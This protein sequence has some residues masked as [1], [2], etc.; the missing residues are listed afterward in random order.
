M[1]RTVAVDVSD[2][3]S[4]LD[5]VKVNIPEVAGLGR[6]RT[7]AFIVCG[8]LS[9]G[10]YCYALV[11]SLAEPKPG[12]AGEATEQLLRRPEEPSAIAVAILIVLFVAVAG[13]VAAGAVALR[14]NAD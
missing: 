5:D 10:G 7:L 9:A 1:D 3:S 11:N 6:W 14:R 8:T 2:E 12:S 4:I 13:A